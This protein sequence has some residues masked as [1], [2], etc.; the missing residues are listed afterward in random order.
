MAI[1]KQIGTLSCF[2]CGEKVPVK[3]NERGT[4]SFPCPWCDF[5]GYAKAGSKAVELALKKMKA[6]ETAPVLPDPVSP[7]PAKKSTLFG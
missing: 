5:P 3:Q 4:L 1:Y 7:A 6:I 2:S